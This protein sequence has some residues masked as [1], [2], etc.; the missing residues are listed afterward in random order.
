MSTQTLTVKG[1]PVVATHTG[2]TDTN[3]GNQD[4]GTTKNYQVGGSGANTGNVPQ[5]LT[6]A[7]NPTNC[8]VSNPKFRR[9]NSQVINGNT[10]VIAPGE[11]IVLFVD[12]TTAAVPVGTPDTPASF[13]VDETWS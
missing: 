4:P 8:T 1:I 9:N 2:F 7:F 5:T 10:I 3:L 13:T 11:N 12:V 6:V